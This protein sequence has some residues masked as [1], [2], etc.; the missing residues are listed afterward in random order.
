MSMM[1]YPNSTPTTYEDYRSSPGMPWL[2]AVAVVVGGSMLLWG[3]IVY[4]VW[5]LI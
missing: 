3:L 5:Q 2:R 4:A 1:D